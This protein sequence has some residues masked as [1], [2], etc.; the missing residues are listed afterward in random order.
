MRRRAIVN[1]QARS[2]GSV[3]P[4]KRCRPLKA[5]AN[6]SAVMSSATSASS[7]RRVTNTSTVVASRS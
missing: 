6:V 4:R 5:W 3:V 7:V 2:S 1:S